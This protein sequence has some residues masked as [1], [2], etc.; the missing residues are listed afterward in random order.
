MTPPLPANDDRPSVLVL[1]R[2][3]VGDHQLTP[4]TAADARDL[5]RIIA[6]ELRGP[7]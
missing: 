7:G 6:E 2:Y 5:A 4:W 3:P 1:A